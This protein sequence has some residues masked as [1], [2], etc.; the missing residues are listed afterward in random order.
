MQNYG[1][2]ILCED[3][4]FPISSVNVHAPWKEGSRGIRQWRLPRQR[5]NTFLLLNDQDQYQWSNTNTNTNGLR[6][7]L[8]PIP[9]TNSQ[10]VQSLL[11]GSSLSAL[12]VAALVAPAVPAVPAVLLENRRRT[13][14]V[15][16][17][18]KLCSFHRKP[19]EHH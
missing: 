2:E 1:R 3:T 15:Q 16:I 11:D 17:P 18:R 13:D 12:V 4:K 14:M 7:I 6:P 9:S 19:L 8:I 5:R 10:S